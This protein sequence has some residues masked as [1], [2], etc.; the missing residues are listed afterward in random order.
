M[1]K[2]N[3]VSGRAWL[4]AAGTAVVLSSSAARAQ[5]LDGVLTNVTDTL[6]NVTDV[7]LPGVTNIRVG[8]GPVVTPAYEGSN[9]Y[10]VKAAPVI[11]FRY[12]DLI[13]VDNN[14]VRVNVFGADGLFVSDNFK[15]GP[16]LRLDFGRDENDSPDLAGLGN[17]GTSLELGVFASYTAGPARARLRIQQDVISGHS[18]MQVIG[19]VSIAIY[20]D[21]RL[22]LTGTALSTWSD[23]D[24]MDSFFSVTAAQALASG[25]AAYDAGSG[26]K[27]IGVSFGANYFISDKWSLL[28][29]AGYEKILSDAKNSPIVAVRG[30]SNQFSAG[31]FAI[32]TF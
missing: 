24:Y 21:E 17:V 1:T 23:G 32:Y 13:Q 8:V 6:S 3:S 16:L 27:D 10:K 7:L 11:S 26:I 28:G 22:T 20:R 12:R 9:D 4:I 15:A 30:S 2:I 5:S 29:S 19:D 18:G 31:V 14:H 25:L